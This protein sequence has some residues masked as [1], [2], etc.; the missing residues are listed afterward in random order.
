MSAPRLEAARSALLVMD[1]QTQIV[2][3]FAG[4]PET[5]LQATATAI[6]GARRH[7]MRVVYVVCGFRAGFPE[8]SQA[9]PVFSA[10]KAAGGWSLEIHPRV[11]PS[12]GEVVI[13]KRRTSAFAGTDLDIVLRANGIDTLVLCG[14]N[15]SGVV[16]STVRH[17][18]D[19]DY[20]IVVLRDCCSDPDPAVQACLLDR[21][22]P[23]QA[24]VASAADFVAALS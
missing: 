23:R 16:L 18:A 19:Q 13:E 17:A 11:A 4:A 2:Q 20:R 7:G 8:I 1:L 5:L 3:R 15:T 22:F 10:V 12:P 21:I 24:T 14:V 6:A 9:N